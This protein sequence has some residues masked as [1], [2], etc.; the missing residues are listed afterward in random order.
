MGTVTL[1]MMTTSSNKDSL[2]NNIPPYLIEQAADSPMN[3][4]QQLALI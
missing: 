2:Y 3:G 4:E 1:V